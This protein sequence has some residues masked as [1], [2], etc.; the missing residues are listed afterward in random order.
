MLKFS[1]FEILG[2]FTIDGDD[3]AFSSNYTEESGVV[4]IF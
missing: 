2:S 1:L 4:R 3:P